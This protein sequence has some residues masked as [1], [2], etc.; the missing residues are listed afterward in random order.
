M[1]RSR[2][3]FEAVAL[4]RLPALVDRVDGKAAKP[5]E[6]Q[7]DGRFYAGHVR[8]TPVLCSAA[9]VGIAGVRQERRRAR[10]PAMGERLNDQTAN[11]PQN[12]K[13]ARVQAATK[14]QQQS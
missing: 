3:A 10:L 1:R 11:R 6:E 13:E 4:L 9:V 8:Y 7:S 5:L 12:K 2:S 14:Q